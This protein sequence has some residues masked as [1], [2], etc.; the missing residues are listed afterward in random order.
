VKIPTTARLNIKYKILF[1]NNYGHVQQMAVAAEEQN[2]RSSLTNS[3]IIMQ[4]VKC[5]FRLNATSY[6]L[7]RKN[8][9]A[10]NIASTWSIHY[11]H[12]TNTGRY[13]KTRNKICRPSADTTCG[14][15]LRPSCA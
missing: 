6:I 13:Y 4:T 8:K 3:C 9:M 14:R 11:R 5:L 10:V 12:D 15:P 1:R 7:R 2:H